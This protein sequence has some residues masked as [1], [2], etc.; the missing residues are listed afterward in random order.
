M[1]MQTINELLNKY[2]NSKSESE[3]EEIYRELKKFY[4]K[5]ADN[6]DKV[7][8]EQN[9]IDELDKFVK[10]GKVTITVG[11]GIVISFV[12]LFAAFCLFYMSGSVKPATEHFSTIGYFA[13]F[14]CLL[15]GTFLAAVQRMIRI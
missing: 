12:V 10:K 4:S 15:L 8:R 6:I 7:F 11:F 9:N 1:K 14:G 13:G 2:K 3:R 5:E